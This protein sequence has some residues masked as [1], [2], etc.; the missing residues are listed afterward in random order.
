MRSLPREEACKR[1]RFCCMRC[2]MGSGFLTLGDS[3]DVVLC[4]GCSVRSPCTCQSQTVRILEIAGIQ[5]P[6]RGLLSGARTVCSIPSGKSQ[7]IEGCVISGIILFF[8]FFPQ[9]PSPPPSGGVLLQMSNKGSKLQCPIIKVNKNQD[10]WL[11]NQEP[12]G[13]GPH[14]ENQPQNWGWFFRG[15]PL[16][17]Q[18]V[19][20]Q[21][22]VLA[23]SELI[24]TEITEYTNFS[25]T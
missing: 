12:R 25:L 19:D 8:S 24:C 4:P 9:L 7:C 22:L 23:G 18:R 5:A 2:S 13:R 20:S 11:P 1:A 15:G 14:L 10:G 21:F 6:I 3:I 16:P 17:D